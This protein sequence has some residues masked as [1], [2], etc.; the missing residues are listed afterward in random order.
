MRRPGVRVALT[1][2][3]PSLG[4]SP[5]F[6]SFVPEGVVRFPEPYGGVKHHQESNEALQHNLQHAQR[7][8]S[9]CG[10]EEARGPLSQAAGA[11][12]SITFAV[13]I[14]QGSAALS[15]T[16]AYMVVKMASCSE[17]QRDVGERFGER[18]EERRKGVGCQILAS[19]M[20][21][22]MRALVLW[23]GSCCLPETF[24][25][26]QCGPRVS[27]SLRDPRPLSWPPSPF[28]PPCCVLRGG[29]GLGMDVTLCSARMSAAAW[30]ISAL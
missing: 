14:C 21:R 12:W 17:K 7:S 1:Q 16:I 8:T 25:C 19:A 23:L 26:S 24:A 20:L 5:I 11:G 22:R 27:S 2:H 10:H 9:L 3:H 6:R 15:L 4:G 30:A 13:V 18:F 29:G 28:L